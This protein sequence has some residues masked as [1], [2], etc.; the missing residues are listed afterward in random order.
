ML[1]VVAIARVSLLRVV[2]AAVEN[3]DNEKRTGRGRGGSTCLCHL[4]I[5]LAA[6]MTPF[7]NCRGLW[8]RD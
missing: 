8:A 5:T 7:P 3:E 2:L 4:E 1:F 6:Y